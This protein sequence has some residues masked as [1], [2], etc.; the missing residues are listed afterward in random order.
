MSGPW[1]AIPGAPAAGHVTSHGW[2]HPGPIDG[3]PKCPPHTLSTRQRLRPGGKLYGY[4]EADL[5]IHV[6][7]YHVP[8]RR[9]LMT[10]QEHLDAHAIGCDHTHG[11]TESGALSL[12]VKR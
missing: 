1:P 3:C 10:E 7:R 2:W 12:E 5:A 6:K 4:S 9:P 11:Y 8:R